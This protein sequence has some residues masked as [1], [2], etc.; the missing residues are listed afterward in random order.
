M[1]PSLASIL[2]EKW[3][4]RTDRDKPSPLERC[5]LRLCPRDESKLLENAL[6]VPM[7]FE[8]RVMSQ[9]GVRSHS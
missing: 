5:G 2:C 9:S 1:V 8:G 7:D 4:T 3:R 6:S